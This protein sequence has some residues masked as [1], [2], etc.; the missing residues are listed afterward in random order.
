LHGLRHIRQGS[1]TIDDFNNKFKLLVSQTKITD[2]LTLID[3]YRNV[4]KAQIAC[5]IL[6]MENVP[7]TIALWYEKA[8]MFN[9]NY[10][11]LTNQIG[12]FKPKNLSHKPNFKF[13]V[14]E[15][16]SNAM[17]IDA[18]SSQEQKGLKEQERC[19]FCKEKGHYARN[20]PKQATMY[21]GQGGKGGKPGQKEQSGGFWRNKGK[22]KMTP[23][24]KGVHIRV[25]LE[26]CSDQ[27]E[28]AELIQNMEDWGF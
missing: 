12:R 28:V 8:A 15:K 1:N 27:E 2:D 24:E 26:G 14:A 19:F 9:N 23:F 25:I 21:G 18:L 10:C 5:Q 22:Q 3:A 17:D 11:H 16:D 4:I 13:K 20:C 7:T 6:M